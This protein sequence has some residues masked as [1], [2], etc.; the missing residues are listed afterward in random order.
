MFHISHFVII[1]AMIDLKRKKHVFCQG[2]NQNDM[3]VIPKALGLARKT[4]PFSDQRRNF[5]R[6]SLCF[7]CLNPISLTYVLNKIAHFVFS[8]ELLRK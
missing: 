6:D 4:T 8:S 1:N 7:S 3:V 2:R 5:S